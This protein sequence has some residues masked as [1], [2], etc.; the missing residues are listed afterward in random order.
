MHRCLNSPNYY[1]FP[2]PYTVLIGRGRKALENPGNIR[3]RE[4][5]SQYLDSYASARKARKSSIIK[6][7]IGSI[8]AISKDGIGFVKQDPSTGWFIAVS[9]QVRLREPVQTDE[10][11]LDFLLP[12]VLL[13]TSSNE[14]PLPLQLPLLFYL[15]RKGLDC[16]D[17]KLIGLFALRIISWHLYIPERRTDI[18]IPPFPSTALLVPWQCHDWHLQIEQTL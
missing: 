17:G 13:K 4:D 3:F 11:M 14:I 12:I 2:C 10:V 1:R 9:D 5:L 18:V 7:I 15:A 8:R 6:S 16:S